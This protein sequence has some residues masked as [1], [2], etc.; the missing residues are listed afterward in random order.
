METLRDHDFTETEEWV[1]SWYA[2]SDR[3]R[4]Q[5]FPDETE[6]RRFAVM[7]AGLDPVLEHRITHAI[8]TSEI[9]PL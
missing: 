3:R 4:E 1:V 8:V 6:A 9:L 5:R 7:A 2:A